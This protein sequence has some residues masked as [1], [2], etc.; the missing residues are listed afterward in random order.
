MRSLCCGARIL[1]ADE[2]GALLYCERCGA[3]KSRGY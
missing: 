1:A 2:E 3:I